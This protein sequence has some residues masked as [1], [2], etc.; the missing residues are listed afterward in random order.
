VRFLIVSNSPKAPTGYGVQ[1]RHLA[2]MLRDGGHDVAV[3]CTWGQQAHG[4][5]W[6]G[7][8]LYPCGW[9]QHS[10]DVLHEHALHWFKGDPTGGWIIVLNDL[11]ATVNPYLADFNVVGWCPVDHYPVPE[12]VL[13]FFHRTDAVPLAMSKYGEA[14][15]GKAGLD[16]DLAPLAV[17]TK[18]YKPTTTVTIGR[19]EATGRELLGVPADAFLVGMVAMNK[20]PFDRKGFNE[21][22]RGFAQFWRE[23]NDAV[24]YVHTDARGMGTSFNLADLATHAGIPPHALVFPDPYGYFNGFSDEM[25]AA[26]YTAFDVLLAPSHGEGF[27]VPLIEA[28]ACGTPVI[29]TDFSAQSELVGPGSWTVSGQ[30][31][32]DG[33]QKASYI[34]P[35]IV[36]VVDKLEDAYKGDRLADLDKRIAFAGQFDV[37]RVWTEH[38]AP[39][40]DTL[41][42]AE[43]LPLERQPIA[44]EPDQVAVVVPAMRRPQNARPLVE[45]LKATDRANVYFI[46][47]PDDEL[48]IRAALDAGANVIVSERGHTFATKANV[49]Y[50]NTDEPWI[51]LCGDDVRFAPDWLDHAEKLSDRFDVIGTN[52][53]ADGNGNATVQNGS[54]ADHMLVRRSYVDT[55]GASLDGPGVLCSE[56]Y[57]HFFVD[58]ELV[59]LAKAR[60]VFSP[61]LDSVVEHLHP[62]LGKGPS[63]LVYQS[64]QSD[65]S[66]ADRETWNARKPLID[67]QRR[68][69]GK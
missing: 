68:G 47:D 6:E 21:A 31:L 11:W 4:A 50:E 19:H 60:G 28:Q 58:W 7:V 23:H 16:P 63:D 25:M 5:M 54:H 29:A 34:V 9:E 61:C 56:E 41:R 8:Q 48:E 20:D 3:A 14:L 37:Q 43:P 36:D 64:L 62:G 17:D 59:G 1:T 32:W 65:K 40:I 67:M 45:S 33:A 13:R 12:E 46:C 69:R 51:F 35:F 53:A 55:Y 22:F 27:C 66:I 42:P 57:N 39:F 49:A 44:H 26:A 30:P 18:V 24:L 10:N 38:W 15:L 52:D 2:R